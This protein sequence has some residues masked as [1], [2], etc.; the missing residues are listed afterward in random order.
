MDAA[1]S[2]PPPVYAPEVVA[3]AILHCAE[4]PQREITAGGAGRMM[5]LLGA[6]APRLM[7]KYMERAMFT[8]QKD[9]EGRNPTMDSL[10]APKRDGRATGPYDGYV[11]QS[12]AYTRGVTSGAFRA[13]AW[14]TAAAVLA[15]GV[16]RMGGTTPTYSRP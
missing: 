3:Q 2:F 14:I 1:P 12:S 13:V 4:R 15:A 5:T 11:M 9:Y 7:D 10:Y 16:R 8:Q 6:A